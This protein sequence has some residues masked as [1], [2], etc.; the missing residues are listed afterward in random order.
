MHRPQPDPNLLKGGARV[1]KTLTSHVIMFMSPV[2][3]QTNTVNQRL[4]LNG[5]IRVVSV[6]A[7]MASWEKDGTVNAR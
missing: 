1:Q 7:A 2:V 5:V 3:V 4:F 6:A